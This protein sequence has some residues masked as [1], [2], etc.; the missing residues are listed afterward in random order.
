ML[1]LLNELNIGELYSFNFL[2]SVYLCTK[3]LKAERHNV[4]KAFILGMCR[5]QLW[6]CSHLWRMES[7]QQPGHGGERSQQ[8][9]T[10]AAGETPL[11]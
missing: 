8:P 2:D 3:I 1:T 7:V 6:L 9:G 10:A 5:A 4:S 11:T